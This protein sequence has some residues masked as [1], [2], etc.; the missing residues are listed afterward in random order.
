MRLAPGE[1]EL[2]EA[3]WSDEEE[4]DEMDAE[5]NQNSGSE[6]SFDEKDDEKE[7]DDDYDDDNEGDDDSSKEE[8]SEDADLD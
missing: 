8:D 5:I 7:D 2:P 1:E 4:G 3:R 6:F